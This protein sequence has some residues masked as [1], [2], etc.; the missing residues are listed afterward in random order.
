KIKAK[1][2]DI[3]EETPSTKSI[4]LKPNRLWK[5]FKPGQH[6][7]LSFPINGKIT[8][9]YYSITS[10]PVDSNL[11]FTIKKQNGGIFSNYLHENLQIGSV[12]ELENP[13]GDFT[14]E[15][16]EDENILFIAGGSGITPI[17]SILN[18]LDSTKVYNIHLLYFS[19]EESEII[20]GKELEEI[21]DKFKG[22]K[23]NFILTHEKNEKFKNGFLSSELLNN[24]VPDFNE[25]QIY[26]CGPESLQ[27]SAEALLP[28]KKIHKE[29][30]KIFQI[31]PSDNKE[32]NIQLNKSGKTLT[33]KGDKS[34]LDELEENGVYPLHGCRSG[35]CHTCVCTKVSGTTKNLLTGE[36]SSGGNELIQLC[37]TIAYEDTELEL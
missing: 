28:D 10:S 30:F 14:I 2:I 1:V 21:K 3:K 26:L 29:V 25:R 15:K 20:F 31:K 33:F 12:I 7:L 37:S 23:L 8:G 35:I 6:C 36:T 24:L 5:G 34:L 32:V 11:K 19:I 22:I 13:K 18:S 16:P 17:Y 9:R 27:I 4:I